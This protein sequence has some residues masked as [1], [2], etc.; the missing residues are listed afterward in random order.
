MAAECSGNCRGNH[1]YPRF[2]LIVAELT[3]SLAPL[4]S[5]AK[6]IRLQ[7]RSFPT[8]AAGRGYVLSPLRGSITMHVCSDRRS[9]GPVMRSFVD[10]QKYA[11]V[12]PATATPNH[13]SRETAPVILLQTGA[14]RCVGAF[15]II[16]NTVKWKI[17]ATKRI[18]ILV[19]NQSPLK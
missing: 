4:A 19:R 5:R 6:R 1:T 12:R 10:G 3:P 17:S 9:R 15:V 2:A 18:S 8:T 16:R 11:I 13:S 7:P 14:K